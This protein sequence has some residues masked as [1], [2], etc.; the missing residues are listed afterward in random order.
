MLDEAARGEADLLATFQD[1]LDH[2]QAEPV[3]VSSAHPDRWRMLFRQAPALARTRLHALVW[4]LIA[5]LGAPDRAIYLPAAYILHHLTGE[6]HGFKPFG[7]PAARRAAQAAWAAWWPETAACFAPHLDALGQATLIVDEIPGRRVG[8]DDEPPGRLVLLDHAGA[9]A[10]ATDRLKM[11]YDATRLAD[12]GYVVAIIR[13]R[14]VWW[15]GP[16]GTIVRQQ[17][18][19]GYPCSLRSLAEWPSARRGLGRRR[20][21][22][23]S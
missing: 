12:G 22:L 20:A 18:V 8:N 6:D 5:A 10:W 9:L 1:I 7:M 23:R 15:L 3:W 19:G 11:P 13:A 17:P 4:I 21:R 16:E 14:A 2:P